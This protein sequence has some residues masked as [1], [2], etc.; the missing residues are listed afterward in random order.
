LL[1]KH[2]FYISK[3]RSAANTKINHSIQSMVNK[4]NVSALPN[5]LDQ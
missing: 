5:Q 4:E 2:Y 1:F 3:R